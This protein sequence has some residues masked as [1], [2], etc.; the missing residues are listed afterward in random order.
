M[1]GNGTLTIT[2]ILSSNDLG[3]TG[4]HQAG[5][6]IPKRPEFLRF[7]PQLGPTAVNPSCLVTVKVPQLKRDTSFRFIYYNGRLT[8]QS[9][10]N[11]YR[12]TT[13]TG[14]LRDLSAALGD[15]AVF[16]RDSHG[17]ITFAVQKPP[18]RG[19]TVDK[20][21]DL[22]STV[23]ILQSGWSIREVE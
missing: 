16:S 20:T 4:S 10:R 15:H 2:K 19:G 5:I 9:T 14:V 17:V 1:G 21:H 12:L 11:E 13:M 3:Q 6:T 22:L 8:G 18:K 7:F 23:R